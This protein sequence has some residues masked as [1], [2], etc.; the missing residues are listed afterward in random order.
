MELT[1]VSTQLSQWQNK[2]QT[3]WCL[4]P[5]IFLKIKVLHQEKGYDN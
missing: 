5:K 2:K 4:V 3:K 1:S